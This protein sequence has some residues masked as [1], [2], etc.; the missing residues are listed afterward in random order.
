[1]LPYK[2][3]K[4]HVIDAS[5]TQ[6]YV[7]SDHILHYDLAVNIS[8]TNRDKKTSVLYSYIDSKSDCYGKDLAL[9]E[10][11]PFQQGSMNTTLLRPVFRGQSLFKLR[12]SDL[13][14]F[15]NDQR[16][17]SFRIRIE[18][19]LKTKLL[20]AGGGSSGT[21]DGTVFCGFLRLP[22]LGNSSSSYNN[23]QTVT[24]F[25]TKRCLVVVDGLFTSPLGY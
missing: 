10:L 23:N 9:V 24:G 19:N 20:Y 3:I 14:R 25:K 8:L 12:G 1:M 4:F 21:R 6:F 11:V 22:L 7:T 18:L 5:L 16:N 13:R 2:N 15:T 17:G